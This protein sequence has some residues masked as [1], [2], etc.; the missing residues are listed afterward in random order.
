MKNLEEHKGHKTADENISNMLIATDNVTAVSSNPCLHTTNDTE[1]YSDNQFKTVGDK[2][3][4]IS[5]KPQT[6]NQGNNTNK[7][8]LGP[9]FD[10]YTSI[11]NTLF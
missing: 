4:A 3:Q 10:V 6:P 7:S 1:E 5:T 2:V 11:E 9:I 8:I